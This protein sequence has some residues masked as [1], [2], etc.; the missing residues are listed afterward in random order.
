MTKAADRFFSDEGGGQG[1]FLAAAHI[2]R[3]NGNDSGW[4]GVVPEPSTASLLAL[5]L[6]GLA[7]RRWRD[8]IHA[9]E[10]SC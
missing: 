3:I 6:V 9:R 4:I 7:V 5:G 8:Q 10:I 1:T 2:Q